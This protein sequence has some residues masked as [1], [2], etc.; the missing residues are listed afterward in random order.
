[1]VVVIRCIFSFLILFISSQ[2]CLAEHRIL[3]KGLFAGSAVLEVDGKSR[4]V[5]AG[6]RSEDG[7]I[8]LLSAD[9]NH[10]IVEI[11][12]VRKTL[13]LD[14]GVG[15]NYPKREGKNVSIATFNSGHYLTAGRINNRWVEYMVD[16]GA[17]Y[18]A[19]NSFMAEQLNIDYQA[20]EETI[21]NTA[22]GKTKAYIVTLKSASVGDIVVDGPQAYVIEGRYPK[23]VLLGNS[24]LNKVSMRVERGVMVLERDH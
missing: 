18:I 3:V 16:T 12:G 1:M 22:Q 5:K 24:F 8:L 21:V 23:K 13:F 10:A 19:M 7:G 6:E 20:G 4:I 17:T 15:G 14:K 2:N 9:S 11:E